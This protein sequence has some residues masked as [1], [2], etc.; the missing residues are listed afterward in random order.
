MKFYI[1]KEVNFICVLEVSN[2]KS[3][4][5]IVKHVTSII[6]MNE[7]RLR[8]RWETL[9]FEKLLDLFPNACVTAEIRW[10]LT[11][12][13]CLFFILLIFPFY[14]LLVFHICLSVYM[15]IIDNQKRLPRQPI[16]N[17]INFWK[18]W[19]KI[20]LLTNISIK[21]MAFVSVVSFSKCS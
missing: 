16:K 5:Q 14:R 18:T 19:N 20:M 17:N 11:Y 8:E 3:N 13:K 4:M 7:A 12:P 9:N 1:N 21:L 15:Y 6:S 10:S 2:A